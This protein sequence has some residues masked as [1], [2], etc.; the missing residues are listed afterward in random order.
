MSDYSISD[1]KLKDISFDL[2]RHYIRNFENEDKT[3][4]EKGSYV[5]GVVDLYTE[6][7]SFHHYQMQYVK[8]NKNNE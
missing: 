1:E 8:E 6:I 5:K 7:L 4:G 3:D 2:I